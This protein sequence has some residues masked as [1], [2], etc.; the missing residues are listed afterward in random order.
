MALGSLLPELR[1]DVPFVVYEARLLPSD[2][3]GSDYFGWSVAT[4]GDT[5]VVGA[6][7]NDSPLADAGAAYIFV[8]SGATWVEQARLTAFDATAFDY[9]GDSVTISGD[10]VV[11]GATYGDR[12]GGTDVGAAYVYVRS[13]S[14]WI[15][16]AKLVAPDGV[17]NDRF[18]HAAA[19]D[20]DTLVLGADGVDGPA[21]N[22][23]VAAYVF[24]RKGG[25][26]AYQAKLSDPTGAELDNFGRD[27]AIDGDRIA[28]G[29][30]GRDGPAGEA[31]GAAYVIV[32]NGAGWSQEAMFQPSS[33]ASGA[34]FGHGIDITDDTIVVGAFLNDGA[35]GDRQGSA[36]VFSRS[37]G[38]WNEVE[39]LWAYDGEPIEWYGY[40]IAI[41][42]NRM[43]IGAVLDGAAS[44]AGRGAFYPYS[45]TNGPSESVPKFRAPGGSGVEA[46]G[47]SLAHESDLLVAGAPYNDGPAFI[48][49]GNVYVWRV[50]ACC[51]G[52]MDGN[53]QVQ[54]SDIA[55]FVQTLLTSSAAA[56]ESC[57]A[58]LNEDGIVDGLD[59]APFSR[60]PVMAIG[61]P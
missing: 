4:S 18:G 35:A 53:G 13:G 54:L 22:G 47:W 58:D 21:G 46:V 55:A 1:A 50:Y 37:G 23:I 39:T 8:R 25:S 24:E 19:I 27:I 11:V 28:I 41:D 43:F 52:D 31:Q 26:W 17:L 33:L 38:S 30:F 12:V 44:Y 59:I 16:Q 2:P 34:Q 20:G 36:H 7:R 51:R 56:G 14:S 40:G 15:L 60:K 48:D 32:R 9:F 6:P 49:Q 61:C 42:A 45:R 57:K 29:A 5:I 3:G 10:T